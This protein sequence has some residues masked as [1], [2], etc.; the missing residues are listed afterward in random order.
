M[1]VV[2]VMKLSCINCLNITTVLASAATSL[3]RV[4]NHMYDIYTQGR[5]KKGKGISNWSVFSAE[6]SSVRS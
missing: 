6:Y 2:L 5:R 1:Y 4:E 3:F